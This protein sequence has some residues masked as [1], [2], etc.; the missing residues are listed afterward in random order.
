MLSVS[1]RVLHPALMAAGTVT[2]GS[3]LYLSGVIASVLQ[4]TKH[5]RRGLALLLTATRWWGQD[6]NPG[7][8]SKPIYSLNHLN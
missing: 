7:P 5:S 8:N 3:M 1:L 4:M 2:K 6:L